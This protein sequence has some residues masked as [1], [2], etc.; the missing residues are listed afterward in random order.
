MKAVKCKF[1][2]TDKKMPKRPAHT[3]LNH[4]SKEKEDTSKHK[5]AFR[6]TKALVTV[7]V[8]SIMKKAENK[9]PIAW[10]GTTTNGRG[11][12]YPPLKST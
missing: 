1:A 3:Q 11:F 12:L 7:I 10:K 4:L 2:S 9:Y 8:Y 5:K 6:E